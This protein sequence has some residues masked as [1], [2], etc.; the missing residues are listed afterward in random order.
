MEKDFK[1]H[2]TMVKFLMDVQARENVAMDNLP[3]VFNLHRS[4]S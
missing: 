4:N 2:Q 1:D 3:K